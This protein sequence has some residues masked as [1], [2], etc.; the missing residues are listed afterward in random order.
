MFN[1][2]TLKAYLTGFTIGGLIAA[3]AAL[4]YA[5]YSGADARHLLRVR[6]EEAKNRAQEFVQ[7]TQQSA[8]QLLTRKTKA[9]IDEAS[10]LLNHGQEY[11]SSAKHMVEGEELIA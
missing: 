1:L 11:L 9:A 6:G 8:N 3:T 4:L 2:T 10:A 7:E 5:P